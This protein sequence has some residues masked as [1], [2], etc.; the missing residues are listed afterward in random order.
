M[1]P[2]VDLKQKPTWGKC[3]STEH[4]I[5]GAALT[6]S[7][8]VLASSNCQYAKLDPDYGRNRIGYMIMV[9]QHS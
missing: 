9:T 1:S 3:Q 8:K 2:S 5:K 6:E 7:S 4:L